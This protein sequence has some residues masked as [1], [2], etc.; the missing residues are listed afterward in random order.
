[1]PDRSATRRA[2]GHHG[3]KAAELLP[4]ELSGAYTAETVH[5]LRPPRSLPK[6]KAVRD[7]WHTIL[8]EVARHELRAGDLPLVEALVTAICRHR[9]AGEHIKRHGIVVETEYGPQANPFLKQER[10]AAVLVDRLAAHFGLTP[11]SRI[12]LSLEQ[13]AGLSMLETIR[14]KV[15]EAVAADADDGDGSDDPELVLDGEAEEVEP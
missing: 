11:E 9:Q 2:T 13:V 10:D 8:A 12:R 4:L 6:T 5:R 14:R 15:E 3:R 1:V 7:L